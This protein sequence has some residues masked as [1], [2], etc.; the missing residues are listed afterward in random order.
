MT[1]KTQADFASQTEPHRGELTA[2]CY[3]MV[4][5][6][7]EADDLVQETLL[8]AWRSRSSYAGKAP[9]RA[10]LYRIATNVCLDFLARNRRRRT[11]PRLHQEASAPE[12]PIPPSVHE[13]IWLEPYP[14]EPA[15]PAE[16]QPEA[17]YTARESL[18]LAFMTALHRLPPR[19]RAVLLLRE[20]LGWQATEVAETLGMTVLAVKSALHRARANLQVPELGPPRLDREQQARLEQYVRAWEHADVA[21]L[22]GLLTHDA[23]FSMPPIPSWYQGREAIGRLVASTVFRGDAGGRW[24]LVPCRGQ[25]QPTF[26]LYRAGEAYAVQLLQFGADGIAEVITFRLPA[27]VERFGLPPNAP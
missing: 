16:E 10:W 7:L 21:T 9:V 15:A 3:R 19:Q 25:A 4:G 24:R 12:E 27:L 11:V 1:L 13:P 5:S 22:V 18:T 8:R 2:H 23:V 17:R 6:V 20:V 14:L 26:G